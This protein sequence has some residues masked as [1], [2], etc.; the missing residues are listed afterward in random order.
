MF[1]LALASAFLLGAVSVAG[2]PTKQVV[3]KSHTAVPQPRGQATVAIDDVTEAALVRAIASQFGGQ[4]I[5]VQ[6]TQVV[7]EP[8]GFAQLQVHGRGQVRIGRDGWIPFGFRSLYDTGQGI[9]GD[10]ELT[11]GATGPDRAEPRSGRM[12]S[13]IAR[14]I[15]DRLHVEFPQQAARVGVVA[16]RS[17]PAGAAYVRVEADGDVSFAADGTAPIHMHGLYDPRRGEWLQLAYELGR[18]AA[19]PSLAIH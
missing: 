14:E 7:A 3:G 1:R 9:A 15:D 5:N 2:V 10:P 16:V 13:G 4:S 11:L 12:A 8:A 17:A 6:L 19:T 18:D